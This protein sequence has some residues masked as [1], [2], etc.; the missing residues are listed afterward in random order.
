MKAIH[1]L[2]LL[3]GCLINTDLYQERLDELSGDG[4]EDDVPTDTSADP[5]T[6]DTGK[7]DQDGDGYRRPQDCN[8]EDPTIHP[9]ACEICEN[10]L[11][12]NCDGEKPIYCRPRLQEGF[13]LD[14]QHARYLDGGAAY[15]IAGISVSSAGDFDGNGELDVIVGA[16]HADPQE[17]PRAGAAYLLRAPYTQSD[18]VSASVSFVGASSN[19]RAG[20]A[21]GSVDINVDG[22]DDLLIGA[23]GYDGEDGNMG[24][25]YLVYGRDVMALGEYE[26]SVEGAVWLGEAGS[27]AGNAV[28][29]VPDM[30]SQGGPEVA[31]AA[32]EAAQQ[33]GAVS[34]IPGGEM[35]NYGA[36]TTRPLQDIDT[37][38]LGDTK[39]DRLGS[40]LSAA[41]D[42]DGD[43]LGDLVIGAQGRDASTGAGYLWLGD[44]LLFNGVSLPVSEGADRMLVGERP[45][46]RAGSAVSA[47][48]FDG[49]GLSD[50]VVG[51]RNHVASPL[52]AGGAVYVVTWDQ[53]ESPLLEDEAPLAYANAKLIGEGLGDRV[54]QAVAA[55][56]DLDCDQVGDLV[57][58]G[59]GYDGGRGIAYVVFG[60]IEGDRLLASDAGVV[61]LEGTVGSND[62]LG[63]SLAALGDLDGDGCRDFAVGAYRY[64]GDIDTISRGRVWIVFGTL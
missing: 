12:E 6:G 48:D 25:V 50:V 55:V 24:A 64:D 49:D 39:G 7:R 10:D 60:P 9:G 8:D 27:M 1:W 44:P 28:T 43:G 22:R 63:A 26:L 40:S 54:G 32:E 30:D 18:L 3:T 38:L 47:G 13:V 14:E 23:K 5:H 37:A 56:G 21:V 11:D 51:A 19:E 15:D 45:G 35:V 61:R 42:I 46:D 20:V 16:S 34:V 52:A 17:R 2:P 41:T 33:Q 58:G 59:D 4:L 36:G 62:A 29:G 57:I 53:L 31:V